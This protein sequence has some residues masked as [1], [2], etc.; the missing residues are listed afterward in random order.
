[1]KVQDIFEFYPIDWEDAMILYQ[2]RSS[3]CSVIIC[4]DPIFGEDIKETK[5]TRMM[6]YAEDKIYIVNNDKGDISITEIYK[7]P[8]KYLADKRMLPRINV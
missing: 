1:M 6:V 5:M 8:C 3:G 2:T 4:G 7:N